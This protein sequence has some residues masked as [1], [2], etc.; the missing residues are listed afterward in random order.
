MI[1][2][3]CDGMCARRCWPGKAIMKRGR[4]TSAQRR[5]RSS[6]GSGTRY[7]QPSTGLLSLY[8]SPADEHL[9]QP[10]GMAIMVEIA[11]AI[12]GSLAHP[13]QFFPYAG[14]EGPH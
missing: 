4:L 9:V 3:P 11:K 14:A 1:V 7:P 8:G 6:P 5:S 2:W 12:S 10:K 13:I